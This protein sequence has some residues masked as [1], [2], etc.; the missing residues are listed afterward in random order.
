LANTG[1]ELPL[2]IFTRLPDYRQLLLQTTLQPAKVKYP[3]PRSKLNFSG[4]FFPAFQECRKLVHY[5][6]FI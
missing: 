2:Y 5:D 1:L 6:G 3:K 4:F